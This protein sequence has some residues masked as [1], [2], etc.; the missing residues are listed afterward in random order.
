MTRFDPRKKLSDDG[1]FEGR[2]RRVSDAVTTGRG[3]EGHVPAVLP[4]RPD[5]LQV[6]IA[7]VLHREDVDVGVLLH[8]LADLR[9][10]TTTGALLWAR[11]RWHERPRQRWSIPFNGAGPPTS[12]ISAS[13]SA[14]VRFSVL[15]S[16]TAQRPARPAANA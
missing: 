11:S 15:V 8:A 7:H 16:E 13:F 10:S 6:R 9:R 5:I 1:R 2:P 14:R 3:G 4:V 12:S